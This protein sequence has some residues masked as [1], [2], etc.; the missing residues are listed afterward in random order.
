M[1]ET[2]TFVG[3]K[4][5]QSD[6]KPGFQSGGAKRVSLFHPRR[7][8]W[9]FE[10]NQKEANQFFET[11][12]GSPFGMGENTLGCFFFFITKKKQQQRSRSTSPGRERSGSGR[13]RRGSLRRS[14]RPRG[15]CG[16]SR[17]SSSP[18]RG[19]GEKRAPAEPSAGSGSAGDRGSGSA[20]RALW[21]AVVV[22]KRTEESVSNKSQSKERPSVGFSGHGQWAPRQST[23][24]NPKRPGGGVGVSE[25]AV[26]R[27]LVTGSSLTWRCPEEATPTWLVFWNQ[28]GLYIQR[29]F[30]QG[31]A[32]QLI[33]P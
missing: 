24:G 6:Q 9:G 1:V 28:N 30:A 29:P 18:R 26:L 4:T 16:A 25:E 11:R 15:S 14:P 19:A 27:A 23:G 21:L 20:V 32:T 17:R 2:M 13:R 31:R 8:R 7:F 33:R 10:G 5:R 22:Q 3:V 12:I